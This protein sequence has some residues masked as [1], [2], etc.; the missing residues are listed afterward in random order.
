MHSH[1][2]SDVLTA[3]YR[4]DDLLRRRNVSDVVVSGMLDLAPLPA[5][6]VS[7]CEREIVRLGLEAGDVEPLSLARARVRWPGYAGSVQAVSA[8]MESLGLADVGAGSDHALMA[9]RGARYHHDAAHYGSKAFCNL[10]L[11][12]DKGLDLHFPKAGHRIPLARG[13]AVIFDTAQPHAVIRRNAATFDAQAFASG[14]DCTQLF[15]TWE[16]PLDNAL[17]AR[18]L[19][20][21]QDLGTAGAPQQAPDPERG[22]GQDPA[23]ESGYLRVNGEAATLCPQT[24]CWLP[25]S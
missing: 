11:S 23:H 4:S 15:L 8:W 20:I 25:V 13:L 2:P 3:Y 12:E 16:L 24:G 9:C 22:Q 21:R 14:Q 5:R 18:A 19:G 6:L 1:P 7:D 17:L 10:F